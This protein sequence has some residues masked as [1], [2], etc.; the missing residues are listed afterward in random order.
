MSEEIVRVL[1]DVTTWDYES[2]PRSQVPPGFVPAR[3][4]G[5][6]MCYV[7]PTALRPSNQVLH[8]EF[9]ESV[10]ESIRRTMKVLAKVHPLTFQEWEHG[11]RCDLHAWRE[12]ALFE[13]I[14]DAFERFSRHLG[15][16]EWCDQQRVQLYA[17]ILNW[18]NNGPAPKEL[19]AGPVGNLTAKR[20]QEICEWMF[21]EP[22]R[23][24]LDRR[25]DELRDLIQPNKL[26]GPDRVHI[27]SLFDEANGFN[28]AARFDPRELIASADVII[29][30]NTDD[31]HE[32]LVFGQQICAEVCDSG[33]SKP[34]RILRVELDQDSDDL[35]KLLALVTGVKG[36]HEYSGGSDET[37][38]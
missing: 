30:V 10:R 15:N 2:V 11:F 34:A 22:V 27:S 24:T 33:E 32:F 38:P 3:K 14:A 4:E 31:E 19:M 23:N 6:G 26:A 36:S 7:D 25:T 8:S 9:P 37:R 1:K 29:G 5:F 13:R 17:V 21:S 35:E 20:V 18:T 12:I 16:N 28:M